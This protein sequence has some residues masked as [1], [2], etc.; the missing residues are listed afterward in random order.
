MVHFPLPGPEERERLWQQAFK[1]IAVLDNRSQ[2]ASF[3]DL[4]E[5]H[6][7]AGGAI[8]NVLRYCVLLQLQR[9]LPGQP[10]PPLVLVDVQAGLRRELSKEGK[11]A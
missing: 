8:I 2:P 11:T 3:Q 5:Q 9:Q 10:L 6:K 4:A 7:V 1:D